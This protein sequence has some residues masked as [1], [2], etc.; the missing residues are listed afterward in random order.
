MAVALVFRAVSVLV[1]DTPAQRAG[2]GAAFTFALPEVLAMK[3]D[4]NLSGLKCFESLFRWAAAQF[5]DSSASVP[6]AGTRQ[7]VAALGGGA[8]I[9]IDSGFALLTAPEAAATCV[10]YAA[11]AFMGEVKVRRGSRFLLTY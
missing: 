10:N 1:R 6:P 4:K 7:L 9:V 11:T 3:P 2:G 8:R 5:Y